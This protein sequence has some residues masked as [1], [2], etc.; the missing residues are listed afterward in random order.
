MKIRKRF[1]LVFIAVFAVSGC[2][3]EAGEDVNQESIEIIASVH[4]SYASAD[5]QK[6]AVSLQGED[7]GYMTM[8]TEVI[9]DSLFITQTMEW[10]LLLMGTTRTV[11]MDVEARTGTNMDLGY[12][13][14]SMSDG[15]SLIGAVA[16]RTGNSVE[17]TMSTSGRDIV[18]INEFEGD[19]LPAFVDL[20]SAT[21]EWAEGDVRTFPTFDPSTGM[22]FEAV[23][24]CE[25][26]ENV[27]LMG[28]MVQAARLVIVQQGMRNT[29]W[30]Y[31]GQIVREEEAGM[32]MILTRVA[33]DTNDN[34]VPSSDLYEVYAVTSNTVGNPRDTGERSWLLIGDIDWNEF[35]LEY[36]GIQNATDGPVITVTST[37]PQNPVV[38]PM[39]EVSGELSSFLEADA[40]IQCYDTV[41]VSVADSLTE[42]A[43]DA[44]EAV[45]AISRFVDRQVENVPTVSLPSAVD[46][47][48]NL[49]GDCNEHTILTVALCRAVGIPAVT[50][51]GIVYVDNGIFGYH[52]WPA[53]WVGEWVAID[54]TFGQQI[55][56]CT[57]IVLAQ[58]SLDAQYVVNGV[59]GR[60]SVEE[61]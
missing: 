22:I 53:V 27:S 56:D 7:V 44:W 38:F 51:A 57:H 55:A 37:V 43:S 42:G 59:L 17:L 8:Q 32:G 24:T 16:V 60:L 20:A 52:A 47:L 54:P 34:I 13:N 45:A 29:V 58:G 36:P 12:L 61:Q 23:V 2:G 5:Y 40:M 41:M 1:L 11:S 9:G 15:T 48:D 26:M 6:F 10:H 49:R 35:E 46:V 30:V 14:M 28:D 39:E 18:S 33:P 50:C 19:F 21:M 4:G 25:A 31:E 3:A